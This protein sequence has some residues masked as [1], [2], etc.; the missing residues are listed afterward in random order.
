MVSL[1][2]PLSPFFVV[3][4]CNFLYI[5]NLNEPLEFYLSEYIQYVLCDAKKNWATFLRLITLEILNISLP[6]LAQMKVSS[7]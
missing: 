3:I 2:C 1:L 6:N 7:F 5:I 4:K